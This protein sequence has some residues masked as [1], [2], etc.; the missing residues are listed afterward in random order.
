MRGAGG[1][2]RGRRPLVRLGV[3]LGLAGLVGGSVSGVAAAAGPNG[4][5]EG[6]R[7]P[8]VLV[9]DPVDGAAVLGVPGRGRLE[10][11]VYEALRRSGRVPGRDLFLVEFPPGEDFA[12]AAGRLLPQVVG[13]ALARSA[14]RRV[15]LV[16][17]G[18]GALAARFYV[19]HLR[20]SRF[21]ENLVLVQPPVHGSRLLTFYRELGVTEAALRA[22]RAS[23]RGL[24]E[25]LV[26]GAPR[27]A[28]TSEADYVDQV[29]YRFFEPLYAE[30]VAE[31]AGTP[32]GERSWPASFPAWLRARHP[33]E[34]RSAFEAAAA[35]PRREL[36]GAP[37]L[38]DGEPGET[39]S[40]GYLNRVAMGMAGFSYRRFEP[41]LQTVTSGWEEDLVWEG[42]WRSTLRDF[43][44]RRAERVAVELVRRQGTVWARSAVLAGGRAVTG[45]EALAPSL[46]HLVVEETPFPG[47]EEERLPA[48]A[49]LLALNRSADRRQ[50]GG[51]GAGRTRYVLVALLPPR[52]VTPLL[53]EAGRLLAEE[54]ESQ[55][56]PPGLLDEAVPVAGVVAPSGLAPLVAAVA[57]RALTAAVLRGIQP[58]APAA[59]PGPRAADRG[60]LAGEGVARANR[61]AL[62]ELGSLPAGAE[63]TVETLGDPP[64]GLRFAPFLAVVGDTGMER[65]IR[66]QRSRGGTAPAW[67]LAAAEVP[68]LAGNDRRVILGAR[69]L[70][71]SGGNLE[72]LL[73]REGL[74]F[75]YTV[76]IPDTVVIP[77]GTGSEDANPRPGGRSAAGPGRPAEAETPRV[78][79]APARG[80]PDRAGDDRDR[81]AGGPGPSGGAEGGEEGDI[82]ATYRNK[83]TSLWGEDRT[84]HERWEWDFGDGTTWVDADPDH[85]TSR[86]THF[87]PPGEHLVRARSWSNKGTLLREVVFRVKVREG[88]AEVSL[89]AGGSAGRGGDGGRG[90]GDEEGG[91]ARG[92]EGPQAS[93]SPAGPE[94]VTLTA[95]TAR[96]PPVRL[97]VEGPSAWV[98]GR[99]AAFRIRV[100][101]GRVPF[102]AETRLDFDPGE[103]FTVRWRRPGKFRVQGAVR[104]T[105]VY[106]F[107]EG[108]LRLRNTYVVERPVEVLAPS[109]TARSGATA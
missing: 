81:L 100:N 54:T 38:W 55:Y 80:R 59:P 45:V 18:G 58:A 73:R 3:W 99:D 90:Q 102:L 52:W 11:G 21:V 78:A 37:V 34:H 62:V 15:D 51:G 86:V 13:R 4:Q 41:W 20:G 74:A 12:A 79:P 27:A 68:L 33:A 31:L 42:D 67:R 105:L 22:R 25:E 5:G 64:R 65:V 26:H 24:G 94:R 66:L 50:E 9:G 98:T 70:P 56:L 2:G 53:G 49:G 60:V 96:E 30:F 85:T 16:A 108:E 76:V 77:A 35:P 39:L 93:A 57:G 83:H 36:G 8:V 44:L 43:L 89:V 101:V 63:V 46:H 14:A 84:Y 10:G 92:E 48:N 29:S 109:V 69:L 95:E 88:G 71:G 7:R 1:R 72:S 19:E 32:P 23:G 87:F 107:P 61:P 40:R 47:R 104:V 6:P 28:F 103:S 106:R 75:R 82:T 91:T 97:E 17:A